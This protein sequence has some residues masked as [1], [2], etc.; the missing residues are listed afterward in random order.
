[1]A[2]RLV[3]ERLGAVLGQQV[4]VDNKPGAG[5]NIGTERR[6]TRPTT[7]TPC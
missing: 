7:A 3:A 6:R 1:V 2:A 4:I 5:G